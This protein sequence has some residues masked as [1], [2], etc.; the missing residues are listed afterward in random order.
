MT[1]AT[2]DQMEATPKPSTS[3]SA[4]SKHLKLLAIAT[5]AILAIFWRDGVDMVRIWWTISTYNHCLLIV[6]ILYYLVQ[7]RQQELAKI[8][9]EIWLPGLLLTA[10]ASLG[11]LLGEAAGV[12]FARQLGLLM[13]LQGAVV[14][15]L[16]PTVAR[17]LI[18]PLCFSFFLVPFGEEFVP[19]LQMVTAKLS[20]VFLGWANIPAFIDGVFISTPTG[21]FEVAEACSGIKFLIAMLAYGALVSNVCFLSWKRRILFMTAAVIVPVIANGVRAF[22]TMYIAHH[23]TLDFA[24]GFDHIFYGWFFFAFVLILVMAIGW[25]FFDRRIDDPMID[26]DALSKSRPPRAF[27]QN[28]VKAMA[29]MAAL[30]LIPVL[31]TSVLAAQESSVPDEIAL[32]E[33]TGWEIVDYQPLYPW[34]PRFDGSS[35]QLLGR[36]R[37]RSTGMEVDLSIAVYDRQQEGR[38]IVGYGQG[39]LVPNTRWSWNRDLDAPA[40]ATA[41]ELIAPG[42]VVRDVVSF[43]RI[44]GKL[45]G[46]GSAVKLE[47]LKSN[48]LGGSRQAVAILVSSETNREASPR[49][50]IDAFLADLGPVDKVADE[51][52][53]LR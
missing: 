15:L 10:L 29:A 42:P 11:W 12:A 25:P 20:M 22:G 36:Y 49:I 33:V 41:V 28:P 7:Q 21:Y 30:V 47:T 19:F 52:A 51:M 39:A 6:P 27:Q 37:N 24:A 45:T 8:T 26:G 14:T 23:T 17:G 35:H 38:E 44:G 50:P 16:G 4:W 5:L 13:M 1:S 48:I 43:Y 9:P 18:F 34:R 32:P 46:S 31:W 40:G 2:A 3:A 53:G